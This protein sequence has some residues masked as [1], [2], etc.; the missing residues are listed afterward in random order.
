M[1]SCIRY[2]QSMAVR[3]IQSVQASR[4]HAAQ[5]SSSGQASIYHV[6]KQEVRIPGI[7]PQSCQLVIQS[8][9]RANSDLF[10][11]F[12]PLTITDRQHQLQLCKPSTR[13]SLTDLLMALLIAFTAILR[14]HRLLVTLKL[15]CYFSCHCSRPPN[16][17]ISN[18]NCGNFPCLK[19][20]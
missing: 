10:E 20:I 19:T 15:T 3:R 18:P 5:W 14:C 7:L 9:V 17:K 4:A 1:P 2:C 11:L 16:G 13:W 6:D 8:V 12:L